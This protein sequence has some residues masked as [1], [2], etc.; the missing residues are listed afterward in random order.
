MDAKIYTRNKIRLPK[1]SPK[2][3][4]KIPS[5]KQNNKYQKIV[6][7]FL[8]LIIA[9]TVAYF[10]IQA[11]Q[12]IL[13]KQCKNMAKSIATKISNNEATKVM[14]NY[15]YNDMLKVTKDEDG[16]V[17]MVEANIVT[18]NEIISQIPVNIQEQM[19]KTE[20]NTFAIKLG[21]FLGSNLFA[22]R[23]P[24]INIKMQLIGNLDTDLKSEFISTGINQT[25]HRIYLELSCNIIILTPYETIE[26]KIVNQVLLAEGV[27]I[28]NVPSS[29][30]NLNGLDT[31]NALDIVE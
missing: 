17:K 26:D 7:I 4:P 31:N 15:S 29:Y 10:S 28:G 12:P 23:G 9:F 21:S 25:L 20:N 22:G 5:N 11:I 1:I 19:E 16:N 13:E 27:I 8:I 2:K 30:Y 3:N 6:K 24:N 14:E 18:I